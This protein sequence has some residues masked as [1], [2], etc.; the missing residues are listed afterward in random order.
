MYVAMVWRRR[1]WMLRGEVDAV[2]VHQIN[3]GAGED[4]RQ[5]K[6]KPWWSLL[7]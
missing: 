4:A 5:D 1:G 2:D 7:K 6:K 3:H